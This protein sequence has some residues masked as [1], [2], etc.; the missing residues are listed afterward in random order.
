MTDFNTIGK[1]IPRKDGQDK[2]TGRVRYVD[3]FPL[4]GMLYTAFVTSPHAHAKIVKIDLK[5]AREQ[6]GV[7]GIYTG[8]DF[9]F[10]IGLYLGDKPPLARKKV[11]HH[12][13]PVVVV[14]AREQVLAKRAAKFIKVTYALLPVVASPREALKKGAPILHGEMASYA[15]IPAIFPEPGTNVGNRT[16]I[17]KGDITAGFKAAHVIIEEAFSF[18]PGDHVFMEDRI[19]IVE[20]K[21]DNQVI[22]RSSTQSP[23]G[24]QNLMSGFFDIPPGREN[25]RR[26]DSTAV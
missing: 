12:G 21:S 6:N 8:E 20:I 11:R 23:F 24:V 4:P 16:K 13:E 15:H 7:M 9:A 19:A 2:V 26:P 3:D 18:P 10:R 5:T 14:V 22:I 17:R 25:N 1:N